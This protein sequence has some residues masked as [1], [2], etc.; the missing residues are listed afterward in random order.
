MLH[1]SFAVRNTLLRNLPADALAAMLPELTHIRLKRRTILQEAHTS[2][3]KVFFVESGMAAVLASTQHDGPMEVGIVGRFGIIGVPALLDTV[4]S[5]HRCRMEVDGAALQLAA[6][7]LRLAMADYPALRQPLMNYVQALLVQNG[8]T[9]LCNLRHGLL[10]RLARW[11]L[12]ASDRLGANVIPLTHALLSVMLG[13]RR[14][15][16]TGALSALEEAGAVRKNRGAVVIA[17]EFAHLAGSDSA[18]GF[19]PT[20]P[21]RHPGEPDFAVAT[22]RV[23]A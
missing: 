16:V 5:P 4:R 12:M 14:A 22:S 3:D 9:A 21:L 6:A 1:P 17:D 11:L 10:Q 19:A 13:V 20:A 18:D 8:Q 23:G 15:G 2:I 7:D